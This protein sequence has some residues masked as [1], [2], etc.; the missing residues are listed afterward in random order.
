M[1][2]GSGTTKFPC[3]DHDA[4]GN[5]TIDNGLISPLVN[6]TGFTRLFNV[7]GYISRFFFRR[8]NDAT[9]PLTSISYQSFPY[10]YLSLGYI[11]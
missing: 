5:V 8:K 10:I 3:P 4:A 7:G 6:L 1:I 2:T 9:Y 11:L